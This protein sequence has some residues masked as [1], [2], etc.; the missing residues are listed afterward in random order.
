MDDANR[1]LRK[2]MAKEAT[3][4]ASQS[5]TAKLMRKELQAEFDQ[6][7]DSIKR[8][9]DAEVDVLVPFTSP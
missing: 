5:L 4:D 6:G 1:R 8:K 9:L 3:V 7:L 2:V